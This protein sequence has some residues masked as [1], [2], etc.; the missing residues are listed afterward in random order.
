MGLF[1]FRRGIHPPQMKHLSANKEIET[2]LPKG[3]LVF[4]L[5]QHIGATA[6]PLVKKG[7]RVLVGQKIGEANGSF[8]ANIHSSVSGI[9]KNVTPM[10]TSTGSKVMSII[11]ENDTKYEEIEV[12]PHENFKELKK[13]ELLEIIREAG[14][15]G[16]GGACFP[17]AAKLNP[18]KE[19][20]ID[21]IIVNGAECEPY[22]TCDHQLMLQKSK[23]VV[24]GLEII[25]H[26]FPEAKI[27]LGIEDN[28]K[29]AIA[30][31]EA[32]VDEIDRVEI[33]HLKTKY[34]QGAEKQLVYSI[35]KKE[36][37]VEKL[38]SDVGCIVQNVATIYAIRNAVI[39]GKPLTERIITV[40]G[41]AIN[42]SKNLLVKL[43]TNLQELVEECESFNETPAKVIVGGPMMGTAIFTLDQPV[44]KG[45][46]GL[47]CLTKAETAS[48][49]IE[50][51]NCI[52]CGKCVDVCPMFLLPAKLNALVLKGDYEGFEALGGMNCIQCGACSYTCPAKRHLT[53]SCK[54]G[55]N[56]VLSNRK[57]K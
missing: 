30:I 42:N 16:L 5:S 22:L 33:A 1:T 27:V 24:E 40:T 53:Q 54:E 44:I 57:K 15:V 11:V 25:A 49:S 34:P 35:T 37:P 3:D 20:S 56:R 47:L 48:A 4:P 9:V 21:T 13:E 19:C 29:D 39:L 52:K 55:K 43:G 51:S 23:E 41:G 32:L 46:S 38:P 28:K 6:T 18:P 12:I 8:S 45:T 17:T 14:I 26:M 7:D 50:Q 2:Y 10:V 31:M 36:I